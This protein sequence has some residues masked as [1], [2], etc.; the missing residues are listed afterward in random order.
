[1][2]AALAI[3]WRR[4]V[5]S[6]LDRRR[7]SSGGDRRWA[8]CA[9]ALGGLSLISGSWGPAVSAQPTD[10]AGRRIIVSVTEHQLW[11]VEGTDT[12]LVAPVAV[13]RHETVTYAATNYDWRTPTG[14]RTVRAKR[15]APVWS[16][17]DW[18][19]HERATAEQLRLVPMVRGR[20]YPLADG[21][22]LEVLGRHVV[23]I[24]GTRFWKVPQGSE[25]II[26]G[27][28]FVPPPGTAQR[29][30]PGVLGPRALDLGD[31]YL[32]H[33]TNEH[34]S[35]SIGAAVSHGCVR[36]HNDDVERLFDLVRVGT[37]VVIR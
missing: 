10:A 32:I 11:L 18:H 2:R 30:V 3:I 28:L 13:G 21:S 20:S 5:A 16:V 22:R 19:Y 36:M 17:P 26:D 29:E 15:Q 34:T 9:V 7:R 37:P 6:P 12:L 4:V 27:V 23:R 25:L 1:M 14:E 8:A 24:V 35:A 33:G 31:G